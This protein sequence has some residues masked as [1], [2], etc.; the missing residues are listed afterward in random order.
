MAKVGRPKISEA[1]A[2]RR[3][4]NAINAANKRAARTYKSMGKNSADYINVEAYMRKMAINYGITIKQTP[5]GAIQLA[6]RKSEMNFQ[7]NTTMAA[8]MN[9][10]FEAN[11][12]MAAHKKELEDLAK[13]QYASKHPG[14]RRRLSRSD[15]EKAVKVYAEQYAQNQKELRDNLET[16]YAFEGKGI[17]GVDSELAKW[18]EKGR[19]SYDRVNTLARLANRAQYVAKQRGIQANDLSAKVKYDA[20]ANVPEP[21]DL[22]GVYEA[23]S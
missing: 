1:E 14:S 13:R 17:E 22:T 11:Y 23:F 5:S 12:H 20:P 3:I 9:R 7:G 21:L 16:L 10:W 15:L 8:Q 19:K 4:D 6:R 18:K 2:L